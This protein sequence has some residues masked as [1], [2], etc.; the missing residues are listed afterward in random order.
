MPDPGLPEAG[1][2]GQGEGHSYI[3]R[4]SL[5]QGPPRRLDA[6]GGPLNGC[7]EFISTHGHF[8][9]RSSATQSHLPIVA[10]L[11]RG[12]GHTHDAGTRDQQHALCGSEVLGLPKR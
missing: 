10:R 1:R 4:G 8:H 6:G 9:V 5:H 7:T 3:R 2:S 12:S 11:V